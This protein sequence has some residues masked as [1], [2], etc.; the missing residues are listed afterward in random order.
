LTRTGNEETHPLTQFNTIDGLVALF[1]TIQSE[2]KTFNFEQSWQE[3]HYFDTGI[4]PEPEC[5]IYGDMSLCTP[6][7]GH[8]ID[9]SYTYFNGVRYSGSANIASITEV[10]EVPVPAAAWLMGSGL[11]GL[12]A[13]A[14]RKK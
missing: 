11:L 2:N 10:S 13:L 1:T 8:L 7:G 5:T 14:R 9:P 4:D 3:E 12:S 6:T